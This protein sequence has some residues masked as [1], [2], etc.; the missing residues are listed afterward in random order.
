M[1]NETKTILVT[2]GAG[3]VGSTFIR[4]ALFAGYRVR[5]LDLLI[6]GGKTMVGF[7]NHPNFEFIY[8]DV[9]DKATVI[10]CL[11]NVDYVVHL[12]AIVG[13]K[14]CQAAPKSAYQINFKGTELLADLSKQS[15][16][17]RFVFA[18][19]CSSYGIS[20]PNQFATEES[21]L[22]PVS[23]YAET[24]IDAERYVKS[25]SND[26]FMT[27]SLRFG[28]SFGVSFRTRFD[29]TVNSFAFE[30]WTS[31]EIIVFAANTWRPYIHVSDM[32]LMIQRVLECDKR[33]LGS[34]V[35]NAGFT[36]Q[37]YTKER[38]AEILSGV[39]PDLTTK[40]IN[41]VDDRR[42]YRVSFEKCES[43]LSLVPSK[44]VEDGYRE[45]LHSFQNGLITETEFDANKLETITELFGKKEK[46]LSG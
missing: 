43:L 40:F 9:R 45:L 22:N 3:Y 31:N 4:D 44:T 28:T 27:T 16:V 20:S 15:K 14:P 6:Y 42:D 34:R 30:A 41:S 46:Y 21:M 25:I 5:C 17:K 33:E 35:Y 13:D 2:G 1:V 23:L 10:K 19:T 12:A 32:S 36:S 29:L 7:I 37:N 18:S 39:M 38:I 11:E 8:G 26:K 24:K